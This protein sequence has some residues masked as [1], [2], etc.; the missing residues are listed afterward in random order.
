MVK[1]KSYT[2]TN[3]R[4]RRHFQDIARTST[5][6]G[7]LNQGEREQEDVVTEKGVLI[8]INKAKFNSDGWE[9]EVGTGEEKKTY[10]CVNGTGTLTMPECI[11]SSQ[12]YTPKLTTSVDVLL[13]NVSKIYT[14]TRIRSLNKT[15]IG[16]PN[17]IKIGLPKEDN[18]QNDETSEI[19]LNK[20]NIEISN[21]VVIDGDVE[22][23]NIVIDGDIEANNIS[24]IEHRLKK[25]EDLVKP[26]WEID[27]EQWL[28]NFIK[29][30]AENKGE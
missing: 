26:F 28:E 17:S 10:N 19:I 25:I 15:M 29:E 23:K 24:N 21:T 12:Y 11:E 3:K 13:D 1:A 9:V 22:A 5:R 2:P 30:H 18:S 27:D 20:N 14:I 16:D 7:H 6:K 8:R 4:F